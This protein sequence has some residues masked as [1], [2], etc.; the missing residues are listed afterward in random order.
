MS[1]QLSRR[2]ITA[3]LIT[4]LAALGLA[5]SAQAKL[6]GNYTKFAQCP[7]KNLEV[8]K[9]IVLA[10]QIRRSGARLKESADRQPGRPAG[11]LRQTGRRQ[12][13]PNSSPPQ[14]ASRSPKPPSRCRAVS[15]GSSTAK[16][17]KISSCGS[18]CEVTFENG[19]TGLNS[20]LELARP[21][22]EIRVS[23]KTTSRP[24]KAW[25]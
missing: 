19:L 11:R 16:K 18:A 21:A 1:T 8:K 12:S 20:T 14:T 25:R 3:L 2:V 22:T 23:A 4:A 7:Y 24:K 17:S 5:G 13:F 10:D 9:C 15:P 6:T